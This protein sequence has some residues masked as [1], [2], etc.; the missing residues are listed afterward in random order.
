MELKIGEILCSFISLYRSPSQT[1]DGLDK[2]TDNLEL[3]LDQAIQNNPYLVAVVGEFNTKWK[4][5]YC[6]DK[7]NFEGNVSETIFSQFGLHQMISNPTHISETY[8]SCIGLIFTSQPNSVVVSG[9]H[10]SLHPNC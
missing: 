9:V 8:S 1:Q 5:W 10:P 4:P 2:F 7:I 3:N 6:C